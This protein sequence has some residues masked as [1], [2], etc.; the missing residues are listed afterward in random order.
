MYPSKILLLLATLSSLLSASCSDAAR[1]PLDFGAAHAKAPI[2]EATPAHVKTK[3]L[4]PPSHSSGVGTNLVEVSEYGSSWPFKNAFK[5]ARGWISTDGTVWDDGR[6]VAVNERGWVT[7]L[8]RRRRATG[9]PAFLPIGK[10]V[11]SPSPSRRHRR[12]TPSATS[13]SLPPVLMH[14]RRRFTRRGSRGSGATA[15]CALWIG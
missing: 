13:R 3:T 14:R 12:L 2:V 11:A 5:Q 6:T 8:C 10:R 4:I 9:A 7:S 1:D 15:R